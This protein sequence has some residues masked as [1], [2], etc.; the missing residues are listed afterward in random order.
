[1]K[2]FP[3]IIIVSQKFVLMPKYQSIVVIEHNRNYILSL[4][5]SILGQIMETIEGNFILGLFSKK[6]KEGLNNQQSTQLTR[7]MIATLHTS[8]I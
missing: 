7:F 5:H 2:L 8:F 3:C 1:M 4:K 6:A